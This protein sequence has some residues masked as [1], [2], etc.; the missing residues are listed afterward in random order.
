MLTHNALFL[1]NSMEKVAR[2]NCISVRMEDTN[3]L[4]LTDCLI[5]SLLAIDIFSSINLDENYLASFRNPEGEAVVS[6]NP[7]SFEHPLPFLQPSS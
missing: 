6:L 5:V 3:S 7:S 2:I 4:S 1:F